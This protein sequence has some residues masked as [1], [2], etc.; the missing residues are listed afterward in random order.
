MDR[1]GLPE[2]SREILETLLCTF[3]VIKGLQMWRA[4]G[5][6]CHGKSYWKLESEKK[7]VWWESWV[8]LDW[9]QVHLA[10][11]G[12]YMNGQKTEKFRHSSSSF[13]SSASCKIFVRLF[14]YLFCA[15]VSLS[16]CFPH[17]LFLSGRLRGWQRDRLQMSRKKKKRQ[18]KNP[19][20][21]SHQR[22]L[23]INGLH[24]LTAHRALLCLTKAL[25]VPGAILP[26]CICTPSLFIFRGSALGRWVLSSITPRSGL[27]ALKGG[28]WQWMSP[29]DLDS[30]YFTSRS[31]H[32]KQTL[33]ES[34]LKIRENKNHAHNDLNTHFLEFY[35]LNNLIP[36]TFNFSLLLNIQLPGRNDW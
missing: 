29:N 22:M 2:I 17:F 3:F 11:L 9:T 1:F 26:H 31:F 20:N 35:A 23:W 32:S 27:I 25:S 30:I 7:P 15:F 8:F 16:I 21:W 14:W 36:G 13:P 19:Q 5:G 33:I 34:N 12:K 6:Q 28:T 18:E 24:S 10:V 4:G